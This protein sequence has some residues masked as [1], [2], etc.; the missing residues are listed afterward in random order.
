MALT[1]AG[2]AGTGFERRTCLLP[3]EVYL[4][5][6]I[7]TADSDLTPDSDVSVGFKWKFK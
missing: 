3:D 2:C 5:T 4:V 6:K 7:D 1:L